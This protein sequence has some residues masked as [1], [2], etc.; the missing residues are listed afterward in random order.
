MALG[1]HVSGEAIAPLARAVIGGL[2]VSTVL[3]LVL[4]PTL[5]VIL[6]GRFTRRIE[7]PEGDSSHKENAA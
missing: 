7:S 3:M 6:D 5:Y 2:A 1:I 4:I